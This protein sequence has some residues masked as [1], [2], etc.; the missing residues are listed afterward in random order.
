MASVR[1]CQKAVLRTLRN[2]AVN[3]ASGPNGILAIALG[4]CAPQLS[5]VLTH[6]YRHLLETGIIPRSFLRSHTC[7]LSLKKEAGTDPANYIP[8]SVTFILCK[9][10]EL[11]L[12]NRILAYL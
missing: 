4:N 9:S 8:I 3:K 10:M 11:V 1:L 7:N 2:L 12:N 6:L 5:P